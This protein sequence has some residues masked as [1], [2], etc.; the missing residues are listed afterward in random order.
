V[1]CVALYGPFPAGLRLTSP[2]ATALEGKAPCAPCFFHADLQDEFPKGMPCEKERM[3]VA[4]K[5]IDKDEVV[6]QALDLALG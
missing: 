2:L 1:P 4:M 6:K 3:C 5:A